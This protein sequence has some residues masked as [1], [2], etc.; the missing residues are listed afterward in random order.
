MAVVNHKL[1]NLNFYYRI[2]FQITETWS[3]KDFEENWI[4]ILNFYTENKNSIKI[5]Q[6]VENELEKTK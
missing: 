4:K 3:K 5:S 6:K 2:I 1:I